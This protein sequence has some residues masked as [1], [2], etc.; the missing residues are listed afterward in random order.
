MGKKEK[1]QS[2]SYPPSAPPFISSSSLS[3]SSPLISFRR[4]SYSLSAAFVMPAFL[5]SSLNSLAA[6]TPFDVRYSKSFPLKLSIKDKKALKLQSLVFLRK[7]MRYIVKH[8]HRELL[9]LYEQFI[10]NKLLLK[11]LNLLLI[12]TPV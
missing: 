4:L 3:D 9:F 1:K 6:S 7:T 11:C 10:I 12:L 8:L 5:L 2:L